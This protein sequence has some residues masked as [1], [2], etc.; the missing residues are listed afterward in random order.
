[1]PLKALLRLFIPKLSVQVNLDV[2][3]LK[4]Q[5]GSREVFNP[6]PRT[7]CMGI[8]LLPSPSLWKADL[9]LAKRGP[10]KRGDMM[11]PP[12]Y[13]TLKNRRSWG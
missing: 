5:E 4:T 10:R 1:M 8:S 11:A 6:L 2:A 13:L 12:F 7:P 9:F 3:M